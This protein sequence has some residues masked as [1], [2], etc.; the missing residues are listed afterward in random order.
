M[1]IRVVVAITST[2]AFLEV[3]K[4]PS[5]IRSI[6]G[7]RSFWPNAPITV[8]V[9]PT[10]ASAAHELLVQQRIQY[11]VMQCDANDPK[12]LARALASTMESCSALLVHDA[13]RP[14]T[15]PDQFARIL[16]AFDKGADAVRPS[17]A[18]TETLKLVDSNSVITET[19]DRTKVR[20][21]STPELIRISAID[22]RGK[23]IGWFVPLK[24]NARIEHV[25]G[26]HESLRINSMAE[27]DLLE[28]FLHWKQTHG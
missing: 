20:R 24:K 25:E 8:A 4:T 23:N 28:S 6:I 1:E 2:T 17:I 16:T 22:P 18:F 7:I 14:L 3:N 27:R 10:D 5:L 13:S 26:N 15:S 21:I 9:T 19:L 11:D 12:A